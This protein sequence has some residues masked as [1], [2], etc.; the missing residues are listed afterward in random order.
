MTSAKSSDKSPDAADL[1]AALQDTFPASDPDSIT[2]A[3]RGKL[4]TDASDDPGTDDPAVDG[5]DIRK[6]EE[7]GFASEAGNR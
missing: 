1:D 5:S 6:A 4:A 2:R 7:I 3:A